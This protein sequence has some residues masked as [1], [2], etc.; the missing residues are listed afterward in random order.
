MSKLGINLGWYKHSTI[1]FSEYIDECLKLNIKYVRIVLSSWSLNALMDFNKIK[2]LC[3]VLDLCDKNNIAVHL[4]L[5]NFADF[6]DNVYND[7]NN[8]KYSWKYNKY[9]KKNKLDKKMFFKH[10]DSNLKS[11]ID[12]LFQSILKYDNIKKIEI[13]NEVDQ[14]EINEKIIFSWI[15]EIV[16]F[17]KMKYPNYEYI[18]SVSNYLKFKKYKKNILC[19][20]DLHMY[21]FPY[22]YMS[23]NMIKVDTR[24]VGEYA[25]YS[26]RPNIEALNSRIYFASGLWLSSLLNYEITPLHWWWNEVIFSKDYQDIIKNFNLNKF[27]LN[28]VE[29]ELI[30]MNCIDDKIDR[31]EMKKVFVRLSSLFLHPGR[32]FDEYNNIKK[33]IRKKIFSRNKFIYFK[34]EE[35]FFIETYSTIDISNLCLSKCLCVYDVINKIKLSEHKILSP[36][37][38]IV[39]DVENEIFS[40]L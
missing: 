21:S 4:V 15:N 24:F 22:D 2:E 31:H 13:M 7:T 26:D 10:F 16:F 28:S 11:D 8:D 25:K 34:K 5:M 18:V 27:S 14:L 17:L 38:Y 32:I 12:N 36:G 40:R 37:L 19:N 6:K 30:N 9:H 3:Y 23:L 20:V 33:Y 29:H 35:I 39:G 1:E